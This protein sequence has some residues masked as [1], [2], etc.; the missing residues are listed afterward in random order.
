MSPAELACIDG[1]DGCVGPVQP[2]WPGYGERLWPRCEHHDRERQQ[3]E[4]AADPDSILAPA[5][6]DPDDAGERWD[7]D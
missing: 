6:F 7:R 5:G 3:R 4:R 1:P 2:R